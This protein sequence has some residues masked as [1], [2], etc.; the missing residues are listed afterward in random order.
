MEEL[1]KRLDQLSGERTIPSEIK[2]SE[3]LPE[4]PI[5]FYTGNP[6]KITYRCYR[7]A[8]SPLSACFI[9]FLLLML[10][11]IVMPPGMVRIQTTDENGKF[12]YKANPTACALLA[13]CLAVAVVVGACMISRKM[14]CKA[15]SSDAA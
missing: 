11:F 10:C 1:K 14:I 13:A 9:M 4:T 7:V 5:P 6:A 3:V 12:K 15:S 2:I 8:S